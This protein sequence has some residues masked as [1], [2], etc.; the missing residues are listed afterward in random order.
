MTAKL[1][2]IDGG[3]SKQEAVERAWDDWR[4]ADAKAKASGRLE[5][6]I[7]AGKAYGRFLELFERA[8]HG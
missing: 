2:V 8:D 7:A 6:G 1:L 5:D 3:L 4:D